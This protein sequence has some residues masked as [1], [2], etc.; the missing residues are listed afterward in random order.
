VTELFIAR[1]DAVVKDASGALHR[2]HRGKTIAE[3]GHPVLDAAPAAFVPF[4]VHL[5]APDREADD[6]G[7]LED[8]FA[9]QVAEA[10]AELRAELDAA[11]EQLGRIRDLL[12][13]RGLLPAERGQAG[14]LFNAIEAAL[15]HRSAEPEKVAPP[16]AARKAAALRAP[17][18]GS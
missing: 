15:D 1:G 16:R 9:A 5:P 11:V 12:D 17:R 4:E 13:G 7:Y 18:D 2:L 6:P 8:E 14:W 3:K 10:T